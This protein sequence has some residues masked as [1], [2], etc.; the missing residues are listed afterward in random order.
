MFR[1]PLVNVDVRREFEFT[2]GLEVSEGQ[3][4]YNRDL[5]KGADVLTVQWYSRHLQ[6]SKINFL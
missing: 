4:R 6:I 5:F 2:F 1:V 3:S